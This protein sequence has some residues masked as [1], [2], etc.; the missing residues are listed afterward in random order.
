[1]AIETTISIEGDEFDSSFAL[2]SSLPLAQF[3][4]WISVEDIAP[5][6]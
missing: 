3:Q 1:M 2:A 6:Y 4:V 5:V